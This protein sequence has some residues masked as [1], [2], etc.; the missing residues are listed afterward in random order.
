L[1]EIDVETLAD[2]SRRYIKLRRLYW[3]SLFCAIVFFAMFVTATALDSQR[4][5]ARYGV[6]TFTL[7]LG[8]LVCSLGGV[9][10]SHPLLHFLCPRCGERFIVSWAGSW[11]SSVCKHCGLKL[12]VG[13]HA[14]LKPQ[15]AQKTLIDDL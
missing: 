13:E 14:Q 1:K 11:P 9:V 6:L 7:P 10:G 3:R 15:S 5:P 2:A 4:H 8:F 12:N